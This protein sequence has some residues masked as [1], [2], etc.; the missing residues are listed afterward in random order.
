MLH[1]GF[2]K[3]GF[4]PCFAKEEPEAHSREA[5][6]WSEIFQA[7]LWPELHQVYI[8]GLQFQSTF[9]P[10][11]RLKDSHLYEES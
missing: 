6:Y 1:V 11:P 2:L 5:M 4:S 3:T 7:V 10:D 9:S 8:S